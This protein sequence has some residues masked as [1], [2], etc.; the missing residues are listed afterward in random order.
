VARSAS[1]KPDMIRS[2][3]KLARRAAIADKSFFKPVSPASFFVPVYAPV[4]S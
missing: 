1:K 4:I 3:E 2:F